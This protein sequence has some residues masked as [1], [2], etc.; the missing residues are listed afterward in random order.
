[1]LGVRIVLLTELFCL[2]N[3]YLNNSRLRSCTSMHFAFILR[4]R[5]RLLMTLEPNRPSQFAS[6]S[7]SSLKRSYANDALSQDRPSS[8]APSNSSQSSAPLPGASRY[9]ETGGY[10]PSKLAKL[11]NSRMQTTPSHPRHS[12]SFS[13]HK[14]SHP[15]PLRG[16]KGSGPSKRGGYKSNNKPSKFKNQR[17]AFPVL[18][19]EIHDAEHIASL[20]P[21]QP[22]KDEWKHNPKSPVANYC[23]NILEKQPKYKVS[24]YVTQDGKPIWRYVS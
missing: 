2:G 9:L 20:F 13:T 15:S 1:M 3:V 17:N 14:P 19:G 4:H 11:E 5:R 24:Q 16:G 12:M 6:A 10:R 8:S 7:S 21:D 23:L 22:L 18:D